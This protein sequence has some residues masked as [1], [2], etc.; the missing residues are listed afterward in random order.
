MPDGGTRSC[1][2]RCGYGGTSC[3]RK[4]RHR[5]LP[6]GGYAVQRAR[7]PKFH[8]LLPGPSG[9]A[10]G[11]IGAARADGRL[12]E[13]RDA[14]AGRLA[15]SWIFCI[16]AACLKPNAYFESRRSLSD[17]RRTKSYLQ[18]LNRPSFTRG[19]VAVRIDLQHPELDRRVGAIGTSLCLDIRRAHHPPVPHACELLSHPRR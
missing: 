16:D 18:Y 6:G 7:H 11:G 15:S 9:D 1:A 19:I 2:Y 8:C 10:A 12:V 5:T 4:T 3:S 14:R 13:M 17:R